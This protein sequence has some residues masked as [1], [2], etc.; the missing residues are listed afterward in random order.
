MSDDAR[1]SF[2]S[3]LRRLRRALGWEQEDVAAALRSA[4]L[5]GAKSTVSD[6]ETGKRLPRNARTVHAL[7]EILKADGELLS[8]WQRSG[9]WLRV[10]TLVQE[11]IRDRDLDPDVVAAN[12]GIARSELDAL[13]TQAQ[14]IRRYD[15]YRDL[16]RAVGWTGDS[17]SRILTGA[18]PLDMSDWQMTPDDYH[19]VLRYL[20]HESHDQADGLRG[21]QLMDSHDDVGVWALAHALEHIEQRLD[22][23][24]DHIGAIAQHLDITFAS[25]DEFAL[26][27]NEGN[28]DAT[29]ED[30]R[31]TPAPGHV[32]PEP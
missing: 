1:A 14:P 24:T 11:R 27:A 19:T 20:Q 13:L 23:L 31:D 9:P 3:E 6:W 29:L 12:A 5:K 7:D 22:H 4:G 21:L 28:P 16:S 25:N 26:A 8:L 2:G 17:I 30:V 32:E 10:A 18:D 15:K